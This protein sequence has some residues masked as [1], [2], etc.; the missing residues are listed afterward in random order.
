MV[1][2]G[3]LFNWR[4]KTGSI[5][6]WFKKNKTDKPLCSKQSP[7]VELAQFSK[8]DL[9]WYAEFLLEIDLKILLRKTGARLNLKLRLISLHIDPEN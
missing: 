6:K 5:F 9:A 7:L 8:G 4:L 1:Q 3:H 2:N